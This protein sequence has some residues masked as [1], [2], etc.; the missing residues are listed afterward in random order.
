AEVVA[1]GLPLVD[2]E[3]N[4]PLVI[5]HRRPVHDDVLLPLLEVLLVVSGGA[6]VIVDVD[7]PLV[8]EHRRPVQDV[9]ML[10]LLEVLLVMSGGAEV[11]V[12]DNP[13]VMVRRSPEHV[14]EEPSLVVVDAALPLDDDVEVSV[15]KILHRRPEHADEGELDEDELDEG[16][17]LPEAPLDETVVV[18]CDRNTPHKKPEHVDELSELVEDETSPPDD[19]AVLDTSVEDEVC[20][21][22]DEDA[23]LL[24]DGEV[25]DVE[26]ELSV[27]RLIQSKPVHGD[28]ELDSDTMPPHAWLDDAELE[29][30]LELELERELISEA[31]AV[32]LDP[33]FADEVDPDLIELDNDGEMDVEVGDEVVDAEGTQS[34]LIPTPTRSSPTPQEVVTASEVDATADEGTDV[35]VELE[36]VVEARLLDVTEKLENDEVVDGEAQLLLLEGLLEGLLAELLDFEDNVVARR[37]LE[38]RFIHLEALVLCDLLEVVLRAIEQRDT[39]MCVF[40]RADVA[41]AIAAETRRAGR[42]TPE[43]AD[44]RREGHTGPA[45]PPTPPGLLAAHA[46][47]AAATAQEAIEAEG[48]ASAS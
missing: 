40:E 35:I 24:V 37:E 33:E 4:T 20:D 44:H 13:L 41:R 2:V 47:A 15:G 16:E 25:S 30:K 28:V 5:E 14:D 7:P 9:V 32:L 34:A 12:G 26:V 42:C 36:F 1:F 18:V 29:V 39:D 17:L 22:V 48:D 38:L 10:P 23:L 46:Q 8:I 3:V 11:V 27:G 6:E 43:A 31:C 45:Q 19:T 21:G